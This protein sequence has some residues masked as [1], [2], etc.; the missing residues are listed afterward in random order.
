MF[1]NKAHIKRL[2]SN[3]F[4]LSI[5]Q[6]VNYILPLITFPYL[7]RVLGVELFGILALATALISYFNVIVDY[8]FNL[9]AVNEI[10]THSNNKK[11]VEQIYS[12][13]ITVKLLLTL[14]SFII[15]S[16]IISIFEIFSN[17]WEIYL[18]TFGVVIGQAIFPV[19]F[20]QGIE[21][22]KYIAYINIFAKVIFTALILL[23]VEHEGDYHLVPTFISLGFIISGVLSIVLVRNKFG[24]RFSLQE[25]SNIKRALLENWHIFI[26]NIFVSLYTTTNIL[27]LGIM[28]NNTI[29]GYYAIAEKIIHAFGNIL[30]PL[31]QAIYP[32]LSKKYFINKK[33]FF[34]FVKRLGLIYTAFSVVVVLIMYIYSDLI[35]TIVTGKADQ[36]VIEIYFILMFTVMTIPLGPLFTQVLNIMK[37]KRSLSKISRDAFIFTIV[38]APISIYTYSTIGLAV[39]AVFAQIFIISLCINKITTTK[40]KNNENIRKA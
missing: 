2:T 28:T 11:K 20:F 32:L 40:S 13:V 4:S 15:L 23:F 17:N 5:L 31:S 18:L 39:V 30:T 8:G 19:W 9:T 1:S 7:V 36:H 33:Y 26:S 35:I 34:G 21:K 27:L 22:M 38:F 29:T 10:A 6:W 25:F 24:V 14:V 12:I 16:L 3:F 37:L